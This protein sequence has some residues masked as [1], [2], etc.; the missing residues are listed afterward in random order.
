MHLFGPNLTLDKKGTL[1]RIIDVASIRSSCKFTIR[2]HR[3][4][5]HEVAMAAANGTMSVPGLGDTPTLVF[6]Q[7]SGLHTPAYTKDWIL[8]VLALKEM[9]VPVVWTGFNHMEVVEDGKVLDEWGVNLI[10]QPTPNPFRGLY[11]FSDPYR[12]H[13]DFIFANASFVV[14]KGSKA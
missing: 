12:E 3:G 2:L 13:G 10:V 4:R 1:Q 9:N 14:S 6:C 8:T 7:H 11:P 5:Y